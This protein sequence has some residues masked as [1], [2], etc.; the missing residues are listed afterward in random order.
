MNSGSQDT[1]PPWFIRDM[2][3]AQLLPYARG[4]ISGQLEATR[5]RVN[6]WCDTHTHSIKIKSFQV[7]QILVPG[8]FHEL[9]ETAFIPTKRERE[10]SERTVQHFCLMRFDRIIHTLTILQLNSCML[11]PLKGPIEPAKC[12]SSVRSAFRFGVES[13]ITSNEPAEVGLW[14]L[15]SN[16][17]THCCRRGVHVDMMWTS[18]H[19]TDSTTHSTVDEWKAH[20]S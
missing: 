9:T 5:L 11:P 3:L 1:S 13:P 8:M 14:G 7:L 18:W 6:G 16:R 20:S 17:C 2:Q 12:S 10:E 15:H 19:H 4:S